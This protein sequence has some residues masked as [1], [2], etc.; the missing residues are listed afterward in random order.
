MM[1][2]GCAF[3]P[4]AAWEKGALARPEMAM[5]V[6]ALEGRFTEHIYAS[7]EAASGGGA[8]GGAGCGCN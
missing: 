5:D 7:K 8:V 6:D 2:G 1:L 4:P 3:A